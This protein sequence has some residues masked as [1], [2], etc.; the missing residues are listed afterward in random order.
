MTTVDMKQLD[1]PLSPEFWPRPITKAQ[2][3]S[4]VGW[5]GL[6]LI[7][8]GVNTSWW[9]MPEVSAQPPE[10]VEIPDLPPIPIAKEKVALLGVGKEQNWLAYETSQVENSSTRISQMGGDG[11]VEMQVVDPLSQVTANAYYVWDVASQTVLAE[12]NATEKLPPASTAKLLTAM[13][14]I[15]LYQSNQLFTIASEDIWENQLGLVA[16]ETYSRDDLLA[17]LLVSSSNEAAYSLAR[18]HPEGMAGFVRAMNDKAQ[19]IGLSNTKLQNPAGFDHPEQFST[20]TDL[21][22]LAQVALTY[23]EIARLVATPIIDITPQPNQRLISLRSTNALLS[24][25]PT[26]LGIKTGTTPLAKE[27]LISQFDRNGHQIE[28]V[29]LGSQQRYVDTQLL[30]DWVLGEYAWVEL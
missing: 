20:A 29:V 19:A 30:L 22:R 24:Q 11:E 4:L 14:A 28:V 7:M 9:Q 23:P 12:K 8:G 16:G 10:L 5:C 15:D 25:D 27:V 18:Q 17:A 26:A 6:L 2:W 13:V 1:I 21:S 3:L